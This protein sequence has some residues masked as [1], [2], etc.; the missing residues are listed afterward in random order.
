VST[1]GTPQL[2]VENEMY[3]EEDQP[4]YSALLRSLQSAM[5]AATAI[6]TGMVPVPSYRTAF[7][8]VYP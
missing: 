5:S 2:L 4:L 7:N 8:L 6:D 1:P 3:K